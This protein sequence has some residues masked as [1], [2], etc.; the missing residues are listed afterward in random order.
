MKLNNLFAI[1]WILFFLT[2]CNDTDLFLAGGGIGGTGSP[3]PED[4]ISTAP[5][6]TS[7]VGESINIGTIT[8]FGH[9]F[10]D[11][12]V[13]NGI[14][15]DLSQ[16]EII[17]NG[18]SA[19]AADL[20]LG[21]I[22]QIQGIITDEDNKT[23]TASRVEVN[24]NIV[25]PV[26]SID[27][28]NSS[29]TLLGQTVKIDPFTILDGFADISELKINNILAISGLTNELG[30]IVATRIASVL[31]PE[32]FQVRG[33]ARL[34]TVKQTATIGNLI[35]D[36]SQT[37]FDEAIADNEY[38][39][40][41]IKGKLFR[42][43]FIAAQCHLVEPIDW[44]SFTTIQLE[45]IITRFNNSA[46][47]DVDHLPLTV[48]RETQFQ[49]GIVTDLALGS[50]LKIKVKG[51]D[52]NGI[53]VAEAIQFSHPLHYP[54]MSIK[55][56]IEMIT[57]DS[58]QISLL[59]IPLQWFDDTVVMDNQTEETNFYWSDLHSGDWVQ[60]HGFIDLDTNL[61]VIEQLQRQTVQSGKNVELIGHPDTVEESTRTL[62]FF[63]I[64]IMADSRTSYQDNRTTVVLLN[65][66]GTL[67][68]ANEFFSRIRTVK[69][70]IAVT[71]QWFGNVMVAQQMV[72][73]SD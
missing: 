38:Q 26:Q 4:S 19:I 8:S 5:A 68:T 17:M 57:T 6:L 36:C 15:Y 12:I 35:V 14:E 11:G 44:N 65:S 29:L 58:K 10:V 52:E 20:Q 59:G 46:D 30:Q 25:A 37:P 33:R 64:T 72:I 34:D 21:M 40:I 43:R 41:D 60:V 66:S 70:L 53:L 23:G 61:P 71:G 63:G 22:V 31:P 32:Q 18:Q 3:F 9:I 1:V 67:L 13:V 48:N 45:G 54:S 69:P 27:E 39:L 49:F 24:E 47:F 62:K 56:P 55:A 50:R 2:A 51:R 73:L 28:T 7:K 16:A 42:K